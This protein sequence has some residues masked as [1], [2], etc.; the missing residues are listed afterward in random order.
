MTEKTSILLASGSPRRQEMLGWL[1]LAFRAQAV[2]VDESPLLEENPAVYVSRLAKDKARSAAASI[3]GDEL[4]LAADTIVADGNKLLG[5]PNHADAAI[6]MLR[7]L[8]GRTHQVYTALA[9]YDSNS[10]RLVADL[11]I[12]QVPMRQY[13]DTEIA[14]YVA[15]GDPFDKAGGYA[16]QHAS[17]NPVTNLQDC[18]AS[19]MGL[20]LCH[21][22]RSLLSFG[23]KLRH[24]PR[25]CQSRLG[26]TCPV[27]ETILTSKNTSI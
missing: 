18:Y 25:I 11:C 1:E 17:F 27:Y 20:P 9:L 5:K 2:D 15:T 24:T 12:S 8:R 13:S 16:I 6:K 10:N 26:Y 23:N 3:N 21:L 22:T 4:I 14:A 19:V 7:Q